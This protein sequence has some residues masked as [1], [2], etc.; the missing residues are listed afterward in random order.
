MEKLEQTNEEIKV[1]SIDNYNDLDCNEII[2]ENPNV[3]R[4]NNTKTIFFKI[5]NRYFYR[6]SNFKMYKFIL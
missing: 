4:K 3:I 6:N 1:Y 5:K 2:L